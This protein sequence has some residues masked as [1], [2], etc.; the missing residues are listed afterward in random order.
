MTKLPAQQKSWQGHFVYYGDQALSHQN[1]SCRAWF[2]L[3]L[4][5]AGNNIP[6]YGTTHWT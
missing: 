6:E 1:T 3:H 5:S 2:C 4:L